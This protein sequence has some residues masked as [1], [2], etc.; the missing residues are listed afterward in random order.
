MRGKASS[1]RDFLGAAAAAGLVGTA[2]PG[3]AKADPREADLIVVNA[4][5]YTIDG[6]MPTA[7]RSFRASSTAT[8]TPPARNC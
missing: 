5:I 1:R 6:R 4:K 8:I 2:W 3:F 7:R